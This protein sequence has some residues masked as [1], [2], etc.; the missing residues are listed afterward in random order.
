MSKILEKYLA[1]AKNKQACQEAIKMLECCNILKKA[2]VLMQKYPTWTI[3]LLNNSLITPALC[4]RY[5]LAGKAVE[6]Q[7]IDTGIWIVESGIMVNQ[8]DGYCVNYSGI[9]N[10]SGGYC[11]NYGGV[12]NQSDGDCRNYG[13]GAVNKSGGFCWNHEGS[14]VNQ[15]GGNCDNHEGGIIN[16]SGGYCWSH[17]NGVVNKI[18]E[19]K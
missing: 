19:T 17:K 2:I 15:S 16:Q 11:E 12:V 1:I 7:N 5:K 8:S 13:G 6:G 9:V 4:Y 18:T 14:V 3:W 10:Q